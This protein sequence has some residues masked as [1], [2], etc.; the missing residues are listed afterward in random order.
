VEN[1]LGEV[2][3][4]Q[5]GPLQ[6]GLCKVRSSEVR[7]AE[8]G[9]AE[10]GALEV[11]RAEVCAAEIGAAEV[12]VSKVRSAEVDG[13]EI[14]LAKIGTHVRSFGAPR[15]P[16]PR[17]TLQAGKMVGAGHGRGIMHSAKPSALT[18][19]RELS[20]CGVANIAI[21]RRK[22][23][24]GSRPRLTSGRA[25]KRLD[26][27]ERRRRGRADPRQPRPFFFGARGQAGRALEA[28]DAWPAA[29]VAEMQALGLA[30]GSA[31]TSAKMVERV[32][33]VGV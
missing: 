29:I 17:T 15:N 27:D 32:S 10:I 24:T 8:I 5:I 7:P 2:S 19:W 12:S 26:T 31:P 33:A 1:C 20:N 11:R 25:G 18:M 3:P 4:T 22:R 9:G 21:I 13:G 16:C 28:E 6:S 14:C 30:W 23:M